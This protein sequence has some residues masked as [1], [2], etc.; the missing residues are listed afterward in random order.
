MNV[1]G[2]LP[3]GRR[4]L[5]FINQHYGL[6]CPATG[7]LLK[8]LAVALAQRGYQ[9]CVIAGSDGLAGG[10][11]EGVEVVRVAS[12]G[13]GNKTPWNRAWHYLSYS[14]LALFTA[15]RR[16]A[17]DAVVVMSTPPMLAPALAR[18]VAWYHGVPYYYNVQ[19]LYPDVALAAGKIPAWLG[20]PSRAL[21]AFLEQGARGISTV[22]PGIAKQLKTRFPGKI[23]ILPNWT[24][25]AAITPLAGSPYRSAWG[26]EKSYV[27]LYSGNL[28]VGHGVEQLAAVVDLLRDQPVEF[29]FAVPESARRKLTGRLGKRPRLHIYP[30]Q[31]RAAL[32]ALLGAADVCL[33]S[34]DRKMGRYMFPCK[35]YSVMSA[36][37]ALVAV[38]DAGDDLARLIEESGAGVWVPGGN[39]AAL[40]RAILAL[41]REPDRRAAMGR[42]G[43][44]FVLARHGIDTAATAWENW[45]E[46]ATVRQVV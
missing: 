23:T 19:D 30:L 29:V 41:G 8:Q 3:G 24:D 46:D 25:T 4:K 34:L 12:S 44:A 45:L 2:G 38:S 26:L 40:A 1:G 28:G 15:L 5:L 20:G 33:V 22:S 9:V 14:L 10:E 39:T 36:G 17:P 43:R 6:E 27:V 32:P 31:P 18:L 21:A 7:V 42:R 11:D 16:S 13:I 37:R 35:A